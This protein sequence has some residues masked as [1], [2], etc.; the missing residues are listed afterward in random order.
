MDRQNHSPALCAA[1]ALRLKRLPELLGTRCRRNNENGETC[2]AI[3][4]RM[5]VALLI[6]KDELTKMEH[7]SD[8]GMMRHLCYF[9][10]LIGVP[11][12][13]Y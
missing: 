3:V 4:D 8:L 5:L 11:I 1:L 13:Y 10:L 9:T 2:S 6:D 12:I 7:K